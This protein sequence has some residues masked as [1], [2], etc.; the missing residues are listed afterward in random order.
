MADYHSKRSPAWT[1]AELL[2]LIS[3]WGEEAVQS[4]LHLSSRNFDTFCEK[5][6]DWDTLQCRAKIKE[7]RQVYHKARE[8]NHRSSAAPKTCRF[9]KELDAILGGDLTSTAKSPVDTS[10]GLEVA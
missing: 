1:I 2:D 8:A 10:A 9:Y 4:Q 3:I 7:L 5:I 6:Y